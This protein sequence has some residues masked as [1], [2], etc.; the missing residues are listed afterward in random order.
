VSPVRGCG[1]TVLVELI[2]AL[3]PKPEKADTITAAAIYHIIDER[4]PTVLLDEGDNI[5]LTLATNGIFRA[6]LNS[7]HR[8]GG[9]RGGDCD[10][11]RLRSSIS[12]W[13]RNSA[14][15]TCS[16][17][18]PCRTPSNGCAWESRP[19]S[20]LFDIPEWLCQVLTALFRYETFDK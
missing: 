5:D 18:P 15:L 9:C 12:M 2:E 4:H 20:L 8:G 11:G 13:S 19:R 17:P 7:G 10:L 3:V 14:T 6:V 16:P 1:K